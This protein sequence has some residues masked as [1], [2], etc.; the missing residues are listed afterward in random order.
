[1]QR[2]VADE[3]TRLFAAAVT[4]L[5]VGDPTDLTNAIGPWLAPTWRTG[6]SGRSTPRCRPAPPS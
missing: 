1:V 3:F 4:G 5:K 6:S 2:A